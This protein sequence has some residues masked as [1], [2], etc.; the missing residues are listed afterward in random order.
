MPVFITQGRYTQDAVEGI[1]AK[2][3]DRAALMRCLSEPGSAVTM[4]LGLRASTGEIRQAELSAGLIQLDDVPCV[5]TIARD[6][7]EAKN[8]ERRLQQ[9]QKMEAVGRLAGG[10]AHDFNNILG[11][12]MG[13]SN[14]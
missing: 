2:P 12:I 3:E 1:L 14:L 6:I 7:T 8:L 4:Q 11:V 10:V 5:L 13:Y 9:A